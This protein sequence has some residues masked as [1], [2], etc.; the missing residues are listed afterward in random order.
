M[1]ARTD[2]EQYDGLE[3]DMYT[4]VNT[5]A[6]THLALLILNGQDRFYQVP[7]SFG[8]PGQILPRNSL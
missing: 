5:A 8:I 7:D 4:E 1:I 2:E 6:Q 3:Y